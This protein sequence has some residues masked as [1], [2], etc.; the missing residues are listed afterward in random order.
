MTWTWLTPAAP[1]GVALMQMPALTAAFD[2]ALPTAGRLGLRH[3]VSATGAVADE[4]VVTRL[5]DNMVEVACHG[6]PGVR[7]AVD[8]ALRSHGLTPVDS[9][10][11]RVGADEPERQ[12]WLGLAQAPCPAVRDW[13]LQHTQDAVPWFPEAWLQRSPTVLIAGPPN[14]GKSTLLNT[15][16]GHQRALVADRPGTTRDLLIAPVE[17]RG[18]RLQVIDSAGLR[19]TDD[20][21][22]RA[23]QD[24]V[25]RARQRA[26]VVLWLQPP[27]APSAIEPQ[28]DDLMVLAKA[29]QRDALPADAVA[30]ASPAFVGEV[31]AAD[32]LTAL[33]DAVLARLGLLPP[34]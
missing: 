2:R 5:A 14:A 33:G 28:P 27:A 15:W 26:D 11:A 12:R 30:W 6:G 9:E 19:D 4:V 22:E 24:L 18:W 29:D 21:L 13:W 17:H 1:A 16:C 20:A 25:A 3:L 34:V 10:P 31:A 7:A 8:A 23:G 32:L